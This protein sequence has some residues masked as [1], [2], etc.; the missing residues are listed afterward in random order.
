MLLDI[1]LKSLNELYFLI[2]ETFKDYPK[3]DVK[4]VLFVGRVND[5]RKGL[6]LLLNAFKNVLKE[7]DEHCRKHRIERFEIPQR[8][9]FIEDLWTPDS[10][11]LTD[12]F[13]LKRK[14]IENK[15]QQIHQE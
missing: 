6:D 10:G 5:K 2:D 11:L 13:K 8:I 3:N 12:A 1:C 9:S 7:I 4:K 15:Y 14:A